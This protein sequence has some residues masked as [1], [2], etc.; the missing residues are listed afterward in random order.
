MLTGLFKSLV[1]STLLI[2]NKLF[3][4]VA[5]KAVGTAEEAVLFPR[6][7][8]ALIADNPLLVADKTPEASTDR[9]APTLTPPKTLEEA[10]G[11]E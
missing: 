3:T 5:S 4:V 8:E 6:R 9:F 2:D 7:D 1:L 10:I 11:K